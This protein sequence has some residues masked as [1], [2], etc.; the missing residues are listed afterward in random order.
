MFIQRFRH[1]FA[2][3]NNYKARRF[4]C[5]KHHWSENRV[6]V[7]LEVNQ[8]SLDQL[9]SKTNQRLCSYDYKDMEALVLVRN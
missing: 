4:N 3:P 1:Q 9:D 8:G 6:P 7:I 2:D 5:F